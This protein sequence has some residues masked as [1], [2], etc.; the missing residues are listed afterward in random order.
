MNNTKTNIYIW[1]KQSFA[2][3]GIRSRSLSFASP[4]HIFFFI[5]ICTRMNIPGLKN[6][7]HR[8]SISTG[9]ASI[10]CFSRSPKLSRSL[11]EWSR[12]YKCSQVCLSISWTSRTIV[13]GIKHS[14]CMIFLCFFFLFLFF[15]VYLFI[16]A[17]KTKI[18]WN[19][20]KQCCWFEQM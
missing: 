20:L 16:C 19:C 10:S 15:F 4:F 6:L 8:Q 3:H 14:L 17:P 12:A 11:W 9:F 13:R 2:T 7:C 18:H 5:F 1:W